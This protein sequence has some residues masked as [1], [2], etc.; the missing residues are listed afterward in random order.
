MNEA[1]KLLRLSSVAQK[2]SNALYNLSVRCHVTPASRGFQGIKKICNEQ[3]YIYVGSEP[4]KGEANAAVVR[5]LSEV[6]RYLRG[7]F[8]VVVDSRKNHDVDGK[9]GSTRS[10]EYPNQT[11]V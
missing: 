1:P 11:S 7:R 5:I 2:K 6:R 3:V 4:R 10:W 9:S 8:P